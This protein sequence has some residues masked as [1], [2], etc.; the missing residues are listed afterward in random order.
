MESS[1]NALCLSCSFFRFQWAEW[2]YRSGLLDTLLNAQVYSE[3]AMDTHTFNLSS[4]EA[5][6]GRVLG[7]RCQ[8]GLHSQSWAILGYRL[9]PCLKT[10]KQK[11]NQSVHWLFNELKQINVQMCRKESKS[12]DVWKGNL[13][14]KYLIEARCEWYPPIVPMWGRLRQ[15]GL[16]LKGT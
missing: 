16:L 3:L 14:V 5:E 7:V 2:G 9:R 11:T 8:P 4:C 10:N 12:E 1:R 15:K 13:A 6:V